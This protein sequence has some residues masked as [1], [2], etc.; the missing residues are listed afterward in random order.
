MA[1]ETGGFTLTGGTIPDIKSPAWE[2]I[3]VALWGLSEDGNTFLILGAGP[4]EFLQTCGV[5]D[6]LVI[7]VKRKEADGEHRQYRLC[8]K[9]AL[10]RGRAPNDACILEI[11]DALQCFEAY[12]RSR[13][14]PRHYDLIE[15]PNPVFEAVEGGGTAAATS[16]R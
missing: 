13:D 8:R 2:V 11:T 9:G 15:W 1:D 4:D 7:E 3:E 6:A 10:A 14:V 5:P 12:Y 16:S